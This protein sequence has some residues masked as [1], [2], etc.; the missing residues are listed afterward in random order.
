MLDRLTSIE[1]FAKVAAAGS[2]SAAARALGLSQT[3]VTKHIAALEGRL[4]ARLVHRSTRKI[5]LTEAGRRYL[6]AGERVLAD[7]DAAE[8][9]ISAEG[10]APRGLLRVNAPVCFGTE[11][12]A[13]AMPLFSEL[14][15]HV[16]IDL[17]LNDRLVDLVDEGWDIAVRIGQLTDSQLTMRRLASYEMIVCAAPAYLAARGTP[18]RIAELIDHNCLG[19]TLS[20]QFGSDSWSFGINGDIDVSVRG[21][22][23]ANNGDALCRAAVAGQGIIYQPTFIGQALS[24]GEL[25]ALP[26]DHPTKAHGDVYGVYAPGRNP[27][28][29]VRALLD[30]LVDRFADPPWRV[31]A[32]N[33][34]AAPAQSHPMP[35]SQDVPA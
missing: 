16:I 1:V 9:S 7:M 35:P 25:V 31:S 6:E 24:R 14:H 17:A 33:S 26:L 22:L 28:A 23:R 8:A 19:Y 12:I 30:F 15:P 10:M 29:K 20:R 27:T 18:R 13:P 4:G 21:N 11:Y 34:R 3:M 5:A 32:P 2:F